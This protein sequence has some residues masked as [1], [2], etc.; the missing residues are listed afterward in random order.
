MARKN[1]G[2]ESSGY[3]RGRKAHIHE[4]DHRVPTIA[5]WKQGNIGDGN[6][7]TPGRTSHITYGLNDLI[8]SIADLAGIE[9]SP[10]EGFAEDSTN[11]APF[12]TGL[13]DAEYEPHPPR[14]PRRLHH[15][16]YALATRWR[17]EIDCRARNSS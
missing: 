8:L 3:Y 7:A 14:P 4:G 11:I 13:K 16:T 6:D 10:R 12:L 9:A 17:L 5:F 1:A 2:K 15:G